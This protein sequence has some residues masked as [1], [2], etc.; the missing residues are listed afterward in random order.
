MSWE[1]CDVLG[2][3]GL[4]NFIPMNVQD[5][6]TV[7][8][9]VIAVDKANGYTFAANEALEERKRQQAQADGAGIAESHEA[10]LSSL[11]SLASQD[12]ESEYEK[13]LEIYEKY[14]N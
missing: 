14:N 7:G 11:F 2:D 13:S 6:T 9:V 3:F 4:V 8:R 12:L 10:K 1:I 5:A